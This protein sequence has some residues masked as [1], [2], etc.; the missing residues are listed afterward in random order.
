MTIGFIGAGQMARA[1]AKGFVDANLVSANQISASD[2][3]SSATADFIKVVEGAVAVKSNAE[4]VTQSNVVFLSIKPQNLVSVLGDIRESI[5]SDKLI[6]SI[7]AG[8]TL[9]L[10]NDGLGTDRIV[11]VMPNTPCLVGKGACAYSCGAGVN[12]K[13]DEIVTRLLGSVGYVTP[14]QESMLDAVT[15]L[16]GS[17]PA[18]V[19]QVIEALSDGGVRMGLPR[20]IATA[21]AAQTVRGAAEMV[22]KTNE[23]PAVLKDKVTSPGGTTIAGLQALEDAGMRSAL[24]AAVKAAT[25]RSKELGEN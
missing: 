10:L 17:G 6:V 4:L 8:C 18:Y 16:S 12:E 23:H 5:N 11:R 25:A 1:L 2:A 13:D 24:I 9:E 21:L 15:G 22:L 19:Y 20:E 3:F 7:V 14:I